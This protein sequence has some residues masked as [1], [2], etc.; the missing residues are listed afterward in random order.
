MQLMSALTI[1]GKGWS[2]HPAAKMWKGYECALM[3][4]QVA[5]CEEWLS[6]GYKDTCL[7][8]TR[9]IHAAHHAGD[10]RVPPWLSDAAF[11]RSHRSNLLRKN[12]EHYSQFP[13]FEV[14]NDLE[15]VWPIPKIGK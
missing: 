7:E 11:H 6:R 10:L 4:Y 8:K 14:P 5:V 1:E 3:R 9:M 12:P 13:G 2:N 15:Y